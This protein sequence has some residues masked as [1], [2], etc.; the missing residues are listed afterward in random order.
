MILKMKQNEK[1]FQTKFKNMERKIDEWSSSK[2]TDKTEP[3]PPPQDHTDQ[4]NVVFT[5]NGKS[6][7][8][9]KVQKDPPPPIVVNNKIENGRPIKK[10]KRECYVV[11]TKE[12]PFHEYIPKI[13]YL[14][15]LKVD[16]S[17]LNRIVKES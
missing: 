5:E 17:H 15:A 11:K 10:S 16:H 9:L 14:Q 7:D 13:P 3:P 8:P 4:V 2:Q 1:N 6:D 12:Y